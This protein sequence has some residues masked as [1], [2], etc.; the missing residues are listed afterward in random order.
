MS[1]DADLDIQ[2]Y[3]IVTSLVPDTS[4]LTVET[5]HEVHARLMENARFGVSYTPPGE[6]RNIT[7]KSVIIDTESGCV[8]CCPYF[9]VEGEL[10]HICNEALVRFFTT[11]IGLSDPIQ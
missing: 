8:E 5:I 6:P 3:D 2:A 11:N 7:R 1:S 10:L 4:K 9:A